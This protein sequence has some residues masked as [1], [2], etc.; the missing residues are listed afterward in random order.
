MIFYTISIGLLFIGVVIFIAFRGKT[1]D[2]ARGQLAAACIAFTSWL[3][4]FVAYKSGH[5][6]HAVPATT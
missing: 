4:R 3:F 5:G 2:E 6:R 1:V